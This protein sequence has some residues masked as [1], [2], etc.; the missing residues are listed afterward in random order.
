MTGGERTMASCFCLGLLCVLA[1]GEFLTLGLLECIDGDPRE[2][3][4]GVK[5]WCGLA[6]GVALARG[7]LWPVPA[8]AELWLLEEGLVLLLARPLSG[9]ASSRSFLTR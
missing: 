8:R 5:C 9:P 4:G 1:D 2:T 3:E 7:F 6:E